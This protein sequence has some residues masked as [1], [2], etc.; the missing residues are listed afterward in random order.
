MV[1][2]SLYCRQEDVD[3]A[4]KRAMLD[5]IMCCVEVNLRFVVHLF[6]HFV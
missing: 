1:V 5:E 2:A 6:G 3:W 4:K